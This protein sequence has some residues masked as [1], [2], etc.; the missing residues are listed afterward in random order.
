MSEHLCN[1]FVAVDRPCLPVPRERR[2]DSCE[3][4]RVEAGCDTSVG[5]T[6]G[7]DDLGGRC[8]EGHSARTELEEGRRGRTPEAAPRPPQS[9]RRE[10]PVGASGV[11]VNRTALPGGDTSTP[12]RVGGPRQQNGLPR[13]HSGP[14]LGNVVAA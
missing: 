7:D 14:F 1:E 8:P 12:E 6:D 4:R 3:E 13:D 10:G 9:A 11:A 5:R 2:D